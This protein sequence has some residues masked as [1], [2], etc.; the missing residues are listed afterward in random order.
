VILDKS[1]VKLIDGQPLEILLS[2]LF[3]LTDLPIDKCLVVVTRK[4]DYSDD[5][6]HHLTL[7]YRA[8]QEVHSTLISLNQGGWID[9]SPSDRY[10]AVVTME[11]KDGKHRVESIQ[12]SIRK[13]IG[14][15]IIY[16]ESYI[17]S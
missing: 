11:T 5:L 3:P 1:L 10:Q 16:C 12:S 2:W 15:N 7:A 17:S 14:K 9:Y 4:R 6:V 13:R 8:D